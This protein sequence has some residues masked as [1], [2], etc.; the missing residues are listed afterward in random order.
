MQNVQQRE[1]DRAGCGEGE[2]WEREIERWREKRDV[3]T[4][5]LN[6]V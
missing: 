3:I 1:K 4:I 6:P 5:R 2:R